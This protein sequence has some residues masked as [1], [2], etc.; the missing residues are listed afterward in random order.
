MMAGGYFMHSPP[1]FDR[2]IGPVHYSSKNFGA[3]SGRRKPKEWSSCCICRTKKFFDLHGHRRA[4]CA[5]C[6]VQSLCL[7]QCCFS[8]GRHR[9]R[10]PEADKASVACFPVSGSTSTASQAKTLHQIHWKLRS[11]KLQLTALITCNCNWSPN[12]QG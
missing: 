10:S 9:S 3:L 1:K 7:E 12:L 8:I 11:S 5:P 6:V 4:E 2:R